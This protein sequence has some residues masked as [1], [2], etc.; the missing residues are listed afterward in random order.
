MSD[1]NMEKDAITGV[2][3][4]GHEWDGIKELNNPAPRWWLI[5]LLISIIWAV[6]YWV[7][8]P[9]WPTLSGDGERGGTKGSYGWTQYQQLKESQAEIVAR[10]A[11]YLDRFNNADFDQIKADPELY[12]F[13]VAGGTSAFKDNCATCHGTGG[14]GSAGYPNLLDDDWLWGGDVDTIHE[15]IRVGVRFTHDESRISE[16]PAFGGM[17]SEDEI[18]HIAD[19]VLSFTGEAYDGPGKALY[20]DQC[21]ACHADNGTGGRDFGAPNLADAIWFYGNSKGDIMSQIRRPKH[22]VMPAWEHRLDEST[23]RQLAIYVHSLGG[24]EN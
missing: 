19:Y 13:A 15:T 18:G 6:G 9:A 12:A 16:M 24:G 14:S 7:V 22:G 3:T 23:I 2:E 10:K 17:L 4:T 21:A 20:E 5:V 8:Y 11:A 1:K